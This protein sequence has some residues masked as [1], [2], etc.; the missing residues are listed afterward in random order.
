MMM[1]Y[2][3]SFLAKFLQDIIINPDPNVMQDRSRSSTQLNNQQFITLESEITI[4]INMVVPSKPAHLAGIRAGIVR[5][6]L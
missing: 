5:Q 3:N 2:P 6:V 4:F 1:S